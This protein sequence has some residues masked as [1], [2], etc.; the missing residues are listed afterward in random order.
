MKL[1]DMEKSYYTIGDVAG[2]CDLAATCSTCMYCRYP[3]DG[4]RLFA[5]AAVN[6]HEIFNIPWF[7][8]YHRREEVER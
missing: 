4:E 3:E 1:K 6:H 5:E 8:E 7:C 2:K